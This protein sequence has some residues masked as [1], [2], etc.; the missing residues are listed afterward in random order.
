MKKVLVGGCFNIIHPGHIYFLKQAKKFGDELIVVLTN[1]KNNK[2]PYAIPAKERKKL[3]ESLNIADKVLIGDF[4]DKTKIVEKVKPHI[5]ALGYDQEL[6]NSLKSLKNIRIKKLSKF[7]T[8]SIK[9][10]KRFI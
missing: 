2:K 6:P 3:L 5:I 9:N 10:S 4:Q 8:K 7:S 1:D